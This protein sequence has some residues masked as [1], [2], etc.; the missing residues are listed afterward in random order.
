MAKR[1]DYMDWLRVLSIF[2]VVGIHVSSK[3]I[4]S[5]PPT[6]WAWQYAH[7]INSAL[8]WCV[9]IFFMLSGALLLTRRPAD[10]IWD[11]LKKRLTKA[12]IPLLFWSCIYIAYRVFEQGHSYTLWEMVKLILSE[13][14]YYHLWFL[15]TIIGLYVMAPF[16]QILVHNIN[17]KAFL[18][19]LGFWFLFSGVFPFFPKF[20]EFEMAFTAGLFEPYIGY[21]MLGAY[22]MRYP[23]SKKRLPLLAALA[24]IGYVVTWYGTLYVTEQEGKFD[25]FFYEHFY[26]NNVVISLFIFVLFQHLAPRIKSSPLI[27]RLS[28][29]TL[30]IYVI[31]PLVQI[32]LNKLFEFNERAIN[33]AIGVPLAWVVIYFVSF[34]IILV[35]QKIPVV[36][37]IVP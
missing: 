19:F 7:V 27:T 16:L 10:S 1:Y 15:Y 3:I 8:R 6:E 22:L 12:F 11:F 21:F 32:Y 17:Q 26:P 37:Q 14:V 30:G 28:T 29:A 4:N 33:P 23:I 31:H 20:F 34:G 2:A 13:D 5:A 25:D 35:L 18:Y 9:P 24:A 36:K